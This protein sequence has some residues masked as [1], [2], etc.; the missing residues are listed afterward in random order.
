MNSNSPEDY[1]YIQCLVIS[2]LVNFS[3]ISLLTVKSQL[4]TCALSY[5]HAF[6]KRNASYAH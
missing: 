3:H 2:Y 1:T 6:L 4:L 5:T